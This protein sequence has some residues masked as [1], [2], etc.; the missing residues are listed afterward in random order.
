MILLTTQV[1]IIIKDG[2]KSHHKLPSL[3]VNQMLPKFI[4]TEI[5]YK[6]EQ[7]QFKVRNKKRN[8]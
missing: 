4:S 8:V 1:H 6:E 5:K 2:L 7:S 3:Q